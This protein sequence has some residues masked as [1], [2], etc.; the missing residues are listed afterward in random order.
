M[1]GRHRDR[2]KW[3]FLSPMF[4]FSFFFFISDMVPAETLAERGL[5]SNNSNSNC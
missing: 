5:E 1:I 3:E 4:S 2:A